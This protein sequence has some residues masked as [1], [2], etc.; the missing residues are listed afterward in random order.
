MR[1][2][3]IK[4]YIWITILVGGIITFISFFTPLSYIIQPTFQGFSWMWGLNYFD[5]TMFG[6]G[7]TVT[8][9]EYPMLYNIPIFISGLI[10]T[11]LILISSIKLIIMAYRLSVGRAYIKDIEHYL[12]KWSVISILAPIIHIIALNLSVNILLGFEGYPPSFVL[13]GTWNPGFA[14]IGPFIGGSIALISGIVSKTKISSEFGITTRYSQPITP[15]ISNYAKVLWFVTLIGGFIALI[16]LLTPSFYTD[17]VS[18]REYY[19][20]WGLVYGFIGGSGSN[21]QFLPTQAS[22]VYTMP[23]FFSGLIP[24]VLILLSSLKSID[25]FNDIRMGRKD[26]KS[27]GNSIIGWGIVLLMAPI[28]FI[29]AISISMNIFLSS[30]FYGP[31]WEQY[32]PGFAIFGPII[33]AILIIISGIAG[34]MTQPKK[35]PI[36]REDLKKSIPEVRTTEKAAHGKFCPNCGTKVLRKQDR[37]CLKCGFEIN[38]VM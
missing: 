23:I 5:S 34:K 7:F 28:I 31:M 22:S 16:S 12:I 1:E 3:N 26:L 13:F 35:I 25:N 2:I 37:Y 14:F 21:L 18:N 11:I 15:S 20:L 24:V 33:G 19:W 9:L 8:F 10:P 27:G 30:I 36:V 6:P 4:N 38:I 29:I 17:V 32:Q